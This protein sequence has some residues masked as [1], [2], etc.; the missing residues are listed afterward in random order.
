MNLITVEE[1]AS[2]MVAAKHAVDN[3]WS[4]TVC[5][6]V[7]ETARGYWNERVADVLNGRVDAT[8]L[9]IDAHISALEAALELMRLAKTG[10]AKGAA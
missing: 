3:E 8:D 5:C 9:D 10:R 4:N 1:A 6:I 7:R 2:C